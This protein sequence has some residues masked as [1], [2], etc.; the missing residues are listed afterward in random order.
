MLTEIVTLLCILHSME[1][2]FM[3]TLPSVEV[4]K[5]LEELGKR[6][7]YLMQS[8]N[9]ASSTLKNLTNVERELHGQPN[10]A[11]NL[12]DLAES[13][14]LTTLVKAL[15]QTGLDD[16]IDHEG[17]Y[18]LFA[19]TNEAFLNI[20]KWANNIPLKELLSFHVARGLI[21]SSEIQ[22][23]LLARSILSKRDI[24]L[25]IYKNGDV[26][27]ANGSPI[28]SADYTAHN[29]VLHIIDRVVVSIYQR[30]GTIVK[31][32]ARCPVFK[33]LTKLIT[34]AGLK[35]A[36]HA[37]WPFT[38]FAPSDEAFAKVP[39]DCMKHLVDNPE[40][41]RQVLL[42][43]VAHGSWFSA[44]LEDGMSLDS[45]QD[46]KLSVTIKEGSVVIGDKAK[47]TAPDAIGS[48]GVIHSI[49]TVLIPP[50]IEKQLAKIM[51]KT[52]KKQKKLIGSNKD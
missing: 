35:D 30:G 3:I 39:A 44:G 33:S 16:I 43:H 6:K 25:N 50:S 40:M 36:L 52:A 49:D 46:S 18:T 8:P 48:N 42:Y 29:G 26:V 21:H 11:K 10:E 34:I 51:A 2:V 22:N 19:P 17:K 37:K 24:R 38:L 45:L 27:T 13:L 31:E 47:V 23:D 15:E 14:N 28:A 7:P 41:L 1:A 12:V 32:L 5:K 9:H 20:P 4:E